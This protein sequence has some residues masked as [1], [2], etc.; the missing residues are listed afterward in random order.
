MMNG[1]VWTGPREGERKLCLLSAPAWRLPAEGE[2]KRKALP[3]GTRYTRKTDERQREGRKRER[4]KGGGGGQQ[5]GRKVCPQF[6]RESAGFIDGEVDES[7]KKE[8]CGR[9]I[10]GL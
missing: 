1:C 3:T 2:P 8:R 4:E 6:N 10:K 5:K 7:D 9:R